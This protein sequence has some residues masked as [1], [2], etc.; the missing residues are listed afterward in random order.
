M[1]ND[2]YQIFKNIDWMAVYCTKPSNKTQEL[3]FVSVFVKRLLPSYNWPRIVDVYVLYETH[4]L[5]PTLRASM[6]YKSPLY[7]ML[8]KCFVKF[9]QGT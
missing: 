1:K 3:A 4:F 6:S 2:T 8:T 5:T 9:H 7:V